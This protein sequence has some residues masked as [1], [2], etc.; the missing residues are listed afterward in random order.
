MRWNAKQESST[1]LETDNRW[2]KDRG[3]KLLRQIAS[4]MFHFGWIPKEGRVSKERLAFTLL[5]L[6]HNF[7]GSHK[8]QSL[9]ILHVS[10]PELIIFHK[11][12]IDW[13]QCSSEPQP[14]SSVSTKR[15]WTF[16]ACSCEPTHLSPSSCPEGTVKALSP[17]SPPFLG[18]ST[19]QNT[20]NLLKYS[21]C[22]KQI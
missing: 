13:K 11:V 8:C 14:W 3:H 10:Y 16:P 5:I 18:C 1:C 22:F 21:I 19:S 6:H 2:D 17:P 15:R 12:L 9:E 4:F 20:V 7:G